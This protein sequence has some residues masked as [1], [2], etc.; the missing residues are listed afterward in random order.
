MSQKQT[1]DT[2]SDI[3]KKKLSYI[4]LILSQANSPSRT[5]SLS[6]TSVTGNMLS[7]VFSF[8]KPQVKLLI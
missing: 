3:Y 8:V 5:S 2:K 7:N 6:E 1:D 4:N